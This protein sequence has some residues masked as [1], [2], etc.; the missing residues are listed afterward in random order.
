MFCV[1]LEVRGSTGA[2]VPFDYVAFS[3]AM[4]E[5]RWEA[6]MPRYIVERTFA[7]RLH[8][9]MD[10]IGPKTC[11]EVVGTNL[12]YGV[13]SVHSYVT[14]DKAKTFCVCRSTTAGLDRKRTEVVEVYGR[15]SYTPTCVQ[16]TT[17]YRH[18]RSSNRLGHGCIGGVVGTHD[19][20]KRP[21][22]DGAVARSDREPSRGY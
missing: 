2:P 7:E 18:K 5:R 9:P 14:P 16:Q 11:A 6:N 13:T 17:V 3:M 12:D 21:E 20:A 15:N 22:S 1:E 4:P 19:L 8:I 10:A